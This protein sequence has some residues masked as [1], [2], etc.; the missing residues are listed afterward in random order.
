MGLNAANNVHGN[1]FRSQVL[2]QSNS[3][4]E[5]TLSGYDTD[6][7]RLENHFFAEVER[8]RVV[9]CIQHKVEPAFLQR[10]VLSGVKRDKAEIYFCGVRQ[11]RVAE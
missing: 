7:I 1:M 9:V 10:L 5:F 3:P 11:N 2:F 4:F 8:R 6:K